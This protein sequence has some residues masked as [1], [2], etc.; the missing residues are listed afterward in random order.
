MLWP[1]VLIFCCVAAS[2]AN[3][4]PARAAEKSTWLTLSWADNFLTI[5]GAHLP[6]RHLKVQYLEAYCRPRST[7]RDWGQTVIKHRTELL[8]R[9]ED[10]KSLKLRCTLADGV[11]VTHDINAGDDDVTFKLVATNPTEKVSEAHWA[12]PC[13]RVGTFTGRSQKDYV[14]RCFVFL[15]GLLTR[16]PTQPWAEKARYTPGQVYCPK[17][18]DRRDVNPR[19]LSALV[20]SNGLISCFSADGKLLMASAWEPYQELFQGVAVCVHSDFRIGGLK[21]GESKKIRGKIYL[22]PADP[23]ALLRRYERDF[24]EHLAKKKWH[25]SKVGT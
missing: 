24:P 16:L 12:Q 23:D 3:S 25:G 18:V 4:S 22:L 5:H 19:P 15:D 7:D 11:V 14:P 1:C 2:P 9:S 17:N 13:I 6:E 10:G 20:P 8:S 21:P